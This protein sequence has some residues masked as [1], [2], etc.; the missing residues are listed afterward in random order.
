MLQQQSVAER[1]TVDATG[2]VNNTV[3]VVTNSAD[4]AHEVSEE[5]KSLVFD[6]EQVRDEISALNQRTCEVS[7]ILSVIKGISE[8]TNLLALNAAIEAARAGAQGCGFAVVAEEVRNLAF[9]TSEATSNIEAIISHFQQGSEASL[10]SVDQVCQSAH[11]RSID[12][13]G[14]SETMR[15]VVDEMSQVLKHAESI[16]LQTQTTSDVSKHIQSKIDVITRHTNETSESASHTRDISV[17]LASLSERLEHLLNQ[18]TLSE[19]QRNEK[20]AF[21]DPQSEYKG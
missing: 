6:I 16:Q 14:L 17:D 15:N 5:I 10:S 13:E 11:Q 9:R 21:S 20:S 19:Q 8:Q 1:A 4:Q 7:S 18:F 2:L 12:V 3:E